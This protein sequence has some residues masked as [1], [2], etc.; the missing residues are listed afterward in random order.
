MASDFQIHLYCI[1]L[2]KT[3]VTSKILRKI[4]TLIFDVKK[5]KMFQ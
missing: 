1:S 2:G 3:E 5:R 4:Q